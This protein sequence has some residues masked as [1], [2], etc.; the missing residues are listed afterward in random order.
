MPTLKELLADLAKQDEELKRRQ[1]HSILDQV[2]VSE[3][4]EEEEDELE[5]S[6]D[7]GHVL[8]E[9][10]VQIYCFLCKR[11]YAVTDFSNKQLEQPKDFRFCLRHTQGKKWVPEMVEEEKGSSNNVDDNYEDLSDFIVEGDEVEYIS[12]SKKRKKRKKQ[13]SPKKKPAAKKKKV[14]V[15]ESDS[16]SPERAR[17]V[18]RLQRKKD[19]QDKTQVISSPDSKKERLRLLAEKAKRK[20]TRYISDS[21]DTSSYT[22]SEESSDIETP[23]KKVS[24]PIRKSEP[25][26]EKIDSDT[27]DLTKPQS[28]RSK[29]I[30]DKPPVR[31][32]SS[33]K[34]NTIK[35]KPTSGASQNHSSKLK[36]YLPTNH[37]T[38]SDS[39]VE[40]S[41]HSKPVERLTKNITTP[42][43]A[44]SEYRQMLAKALSKKA[45]RNMYSSTGLVYS[46]EES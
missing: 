25:A 22:S 18:K 23:P 14:V 42:P 17:K 7:S 13:L 5:S 40:P 9:A 15:E 43:G 46:D 21:S 30:A 39:E 35:K 4:E 41:R 19:I 31:P 12:D 28:A 11:K 1:N 3:D 16:S 33:S 29:K 2:S 6:D 24:K 45:N 27:D 10:P 26:Y 20:N 34:T 32:T 38:I 37:I 44:K 8:G 36:Q